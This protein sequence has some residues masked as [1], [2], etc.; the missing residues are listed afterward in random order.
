MNKEDILKRSREE[1]RNGDEYEKT[2]KKNA[3][4]NS[5]LVPTICLT[6]LAIS[7]YLGITNGNVVINN[8][9]F[10][11]QDVLWFIVFLTNLVEY[12]SKYVYLKQ[13]RHLANAMFWLCGLICCLI[14]MFRT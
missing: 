14:A 11:L 9:K 4:N 12:A 6:L 7:C 5:Y 1:N 3:L 8:M 10:K 13:K 2:K